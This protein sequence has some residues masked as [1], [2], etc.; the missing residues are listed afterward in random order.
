MACGA[1]PSAGHAETLKIGGTG[2]AMGAIRLLAEAFRKSHPDADFVFLGRMGSGGAIQAVLAGDIDIGISA[3]ALS[4]E[5]RRLGLK[6][7]DYART[8]F[9]VVA[10]GKRGVSGFSLGELTDIYAGKRKSWP[11][12][13]P[14]R[15][16]LRPESDTDIAVLKMM[17]PGMKQAVQD[18]VS[19]KGMIIAM[20]DSENA[21]KLEDIPGA[22]GTA[23]LAQILSEKRKLKPMSL[24]GRDPAVKGFANP[25][26]P[27]SKT[28]SIVSRSKPIRLAT[29]FV[30]FVLS[31]AGRNILVRTGHLALTE[32]RGR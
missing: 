25:S 20:T 15:L 12:G 3:K 18:A 6:Q 1:V 28:F 17:S 10:D 16:V 26:Y 23:T 5:K 7:V 19:R 27:Y 8:N 29:E 22:L 11:D 4:E 32:R 31:D 21:D 9:V 14:I 13:T 24:D 30:D 2:G